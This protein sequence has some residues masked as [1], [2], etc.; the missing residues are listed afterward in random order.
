[1]VDIKGIQLAIPTPCQQR[2]QDMKSQ[3]TG[4]FCA[5]CQRTVVDFV[6]MSDQ[7]IMAYLANTEGHVCGRLSA[8]QLNRNLIHVATVSGNTMKQRWL[9]FVTAGLMSWSTAQGQDERPAGKQA[10]MSEI[11]RPKS[12]AMTKGIAQQ[13]DNPVIN[14][15]T[16]V[17]E[18]R[19][20]AENGKDHLPGA[21]VVAKGTN[22]GAVTDTAG[23]FK[24]SIPH[25][26]GNKLILKVGSIGFISQEI[27]VSATK[28][29]QLVISLS[30]D[31][32]LLG[33]VIYT[34]Y[35]EAKKKPTFY[36]KLK[37]RF[38]TSY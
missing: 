35:V 23:L 22:L 5:S 32:Q 28:K 38:R 8:N 31:S 13:E 19:V 17:I 4:R 25:D 9:G 30:E 11:A 16:W 2:W 26:Q 7:Q 20:I 33:E 36:Q 12:T 37:R 15:S 24:L 18:G 6:E 14:D 10:L 27:D 34:G 29:R 1:M 21:F 3:E